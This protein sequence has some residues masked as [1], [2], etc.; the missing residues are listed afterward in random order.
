MRAPN[1]RRHVAHIEWIVTWVLFMRWLLQDI[2][3][4]I[5]QSWYFL[6][7]PFHNSLNYFTIIHKYIFPKR[8]ACAP[9]ITNHDK[10]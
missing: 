3:I 4:S 10:I 7:H 5:S 1:L 8:L 2:I 9:V 6:I